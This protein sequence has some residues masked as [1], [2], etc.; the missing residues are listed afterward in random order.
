MSEVKIYN[1]LSLSLNMAL[2]GLVWHFY[3]GLQVDLQV[4]L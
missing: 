2:F 1:Q 4:L 3:Y